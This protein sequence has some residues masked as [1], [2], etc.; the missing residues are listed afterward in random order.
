MDFHILPSMNPDGF[1]RATEGQCEGGDLKSGRTNSNAKDL[2]RN[3]PTWND[4][5]NLTVFVST[6]LSQH[7]RLLKA[8]SA[9]IKSRS[10][11]N[12]VFLT[13]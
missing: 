12:R 8:I 4:L 5:V 13:N 3:F 1:E 6:S 7:K 10:Y 11:K 2:N 9:P